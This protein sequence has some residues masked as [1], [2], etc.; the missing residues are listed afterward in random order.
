MTP[1][2]PF[3]VDRRDAPSRGDL[4]FV[5]IGTTEPG[6]IGA[7]ARAIK[8]MGFRRLVLV[9]PPDGWKTHHAVAMAHGAEEILEEAEVHDRLDEAIAG[10]SWV[11]GTSR[12]LRRFQAKTVTPR[13]WGERL[14][15]IAPGES[16]AV[17]FGPEKTG[18]VNEDILRCRLI[19]TI[20][21]PI[22][23]PSLNLSQT[24]MLMAYECGLAL[25][26]PAETVG[27][28]KL[29]TDEEL[30]R[31]YGHMESALAL[32]AMKEK[33][34]RSTMRH[35]RLILGR[36]QLSQEEIITFH[37]IAARVEGPK[38]RVKRAPPSGEP[39]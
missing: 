19:A 23:H 15:A 9:A 16:V 30:E 14:S 25:R 37:G 38:P 20:P 8:A 10:C 6:N 1:D 3:W 29:A 32:S 39:A 28:P 18:L 11:V 12:R 17:L 35:L 22:D 36:A 26:Q 33:K 13:V 2:G 5:L 7:S 31:M 34:V 24:V 21:S 27:S 4:R